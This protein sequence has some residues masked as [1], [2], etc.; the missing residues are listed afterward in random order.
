MTLT[1][2]QHRVRDTQ[3][4]VT[5][6]LAVDVENNSVVVSKRSNPAAVATNIFGGRSL[7]KVQAAS[8]ALKYHYSATWEVHA[9]LTPPSPLRLG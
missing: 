7:T 8:A 6:S 4:L 1:G 5:G 9:P 2:L 3:V